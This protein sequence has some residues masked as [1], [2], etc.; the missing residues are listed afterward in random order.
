MNLRR[1]RTKWVLSVLGAAC[2][3]LL[4]SSASASTESSARADVKPPSG[5]PDLSKMAVRVDDL[6]PGAKIGRQGYVKPEDLVASYLRTFKFGTARLGG[7]RLGFLTSYVDLTPTV[8][9][10]KVAL[11]FEGFWAASLDADAT[12]AEFTRNTGVRPTFVRIGDPVDMRAGD[13]AVAWTV[14]IGTR[15]GDIREVAAVVRV[16]R[17]LAYLYFSGLPRVKIGIADARALARAVSRHIVEGLRPVNRSLPVIS[18]TTQAGQTLSATTGRW[19]NKPGGGYTYA[20]RRCNAAGAG[21][22]SIPGA[23]GRSYALTSAET[24]FTIRVAVTA[25]SARGRAT[26]VSAA[27]SPVAPTP[28]PPVM[29]APPTISGTPAVGMTLTASQ[30]TWTGAPTSFAYSWQR[31]DALGGSCTDITGATSQTYVLVPADAGLTVRVA[32]TATN[33]IGSTTAVSLPTAAVAP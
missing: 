32:V 11:F 28:A 13:D 22:T 14:R 19:I 16:D 31:C 24:G 4:V 25:R 29:T 23:T 20:W 33:A 30:G 6:A 8:D 9:D 5:I 7:K 1:T 12:A 17:I 27:T 26:A 18:G 2:G 10:A 15:G 3:L 21:C